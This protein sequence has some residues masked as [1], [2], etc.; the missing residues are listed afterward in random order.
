MQIIPDRVSSSHPNPLGDGTILFHLF[1]KLLLDLER[2][3][4]RLKTLT[5]VALVSNVRRI[6]RCG[7]SNFSSTLPGRSAAANR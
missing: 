2:L 1:G 5:H 6:V 3:F 4:R 7:I